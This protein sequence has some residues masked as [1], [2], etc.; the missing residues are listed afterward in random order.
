MEMSTS[1]DAV[2]PNVV[3]DATGRLAQLSG[4]YVQLAQAMGMRP[5][6]DAHWNESMFLAAIH[7]LTR[8]QGMEDKVQFINGEVSPVK[9]LNFEEQMADLY[10]ASKGDMSLI[11]QTYSAVIQDIEILCPPVDDILPCGDGHSEFDVDYY[12][13]WNAFHLGMMQKYAKSITYANFLLALKD[14]ELDKNASFLRALRFE[15]TRRGQ[16]PS[17]G[18]PASIDNDNNMTYCA[19]C[20]EPCDRIRCDFCWRHRTP[21]RSYCSDHSVELIHRDGDG[22]ED[23]AKA[24]GKCATE[25][26]ACK[27]WTKKV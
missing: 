6:H 4:V 12:R 17:T 25:Q 22:D 13:G 3:H 21:I 19:V 24:C 2:G 7:S 16:A 9:P 15:A 8:T 23:S 18:T 20:T 5:E 11:I 14:S 27:R 10:K 1:F 26:L